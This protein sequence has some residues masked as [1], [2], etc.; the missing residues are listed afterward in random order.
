MQR[1][2]DATKNILKGDKNITFDESLEAEFNTAFKPIKAAIRKDLKNIAKELPVH[3][4][5]HEKYLEGMQ[6]YSNPDPKKQKD[7]MAFRE[8]CVTLESW[9]SKKHAPKFIQQ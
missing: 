2:L 1:F 6:K 5:M 8:G 4:K 3:Q 7:N 9:L